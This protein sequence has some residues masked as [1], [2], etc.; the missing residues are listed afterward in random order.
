MVPF[1]GLTKSSGAPEK[2]PLALALRA[3]FVYAKY[4][5][6]SWFN[7]PALLAK[8][9]YCGASVSARITPRNDELRQSIY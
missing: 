6:G 1:L 5:A 4:F 7:R 2:L 9:T 3:S 8:Q